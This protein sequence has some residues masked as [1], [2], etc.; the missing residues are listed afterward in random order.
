MVAGDGA[1]LAFEG[2]KV[3]ENGQSLLLKSLHSSSC[4]S[5]VIYGGSNDDA[6]AEI[7]AALTLCEGN[8]P[9]SVRR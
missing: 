8:G 5:S 7:I 1:E 3:A 6:A 2:S 4:S 9:G